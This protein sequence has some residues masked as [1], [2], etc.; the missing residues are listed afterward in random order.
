MTPNK[1][2]VLKHLKKAGVLRFKA[3]RQK[4]NEEIEKGRV[5]SEPALFHSLL[6]DDLRIYSG[7]Q[8][9]K[10]HKNFNK[11][12]HTV[13]IHSLETNFDTPGSIGA[14]MA[15]R[16]ENLKNLKNQQQSC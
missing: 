9:A 10:S 14:I 13:P 7:E 4:L 3:V 8:S 1:V 5:K 6:E 12:E 11:K 2:I 16:I 15:S